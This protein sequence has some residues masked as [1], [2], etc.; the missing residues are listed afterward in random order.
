[1][2]RSLSEKYLAVETPEVWI[3]LEEQHPRIT[4]HCRCGLN[5]PLPAAQFEFVGRRVVLNLFTR[6]ERIL[7]HRRGRRVSDSMPPAERR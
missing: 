4:E 3:T 5:F 7:A 1:M 6:R 2:K